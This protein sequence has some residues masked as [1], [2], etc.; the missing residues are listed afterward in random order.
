MVEDQKIRLKLANAS[1]TPRCGRR[2]TRKVEYIDAT[3]TICRSTV[4]GS[5]F[6]WINDEIP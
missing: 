2:Y 5:V 4:A 3:V 1:P 6:G